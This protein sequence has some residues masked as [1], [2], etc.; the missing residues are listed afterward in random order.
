MARFWDKKRRET[1]IRNDNEIHRAYF[2]VVGELGGIAAYI[3]R[4]EIYRRVAAKVHRCTKTIANV[5]NY[6]EYTER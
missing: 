5:L 4:G 3:S 6:T 2:E 1:T